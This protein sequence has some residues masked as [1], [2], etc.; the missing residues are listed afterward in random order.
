MSTQVQETF[1]KS[2]NDMESELA[3]IGFTYHL[4]IKKGYATYVHYKS[5]K[6]IQA[7]FMLGPSDWNVELVITTVERKY[8]FKDLLLV[9]YISQWTRENKFQQRTSGRVKDEIVWF[10]DLLKFVMKTELLKN[11]A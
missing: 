3:N 1:I 9:P 5:T 6:N 7:S 8:E 10:V 2:M 4:T 11:N